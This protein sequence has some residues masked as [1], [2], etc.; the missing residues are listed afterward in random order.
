M[1]TFIFF[2]ALLTAAVAAAV[3]FPLLRRRE[4]SQPA[5]FA[6]IVA[7]AVVVIG[8]SACYVWLSNW[9]WQAPAPANTPETM[10]AQ[11]ARRLERSPD[12][13][14]G[15]L[16]LG[17]SYVV[18]QQY[19]LAT[20][21]YQRADR[22]SD[23]RNV[24]ALTGLAEALALTDESELDGRAGRLL[25]QALAVDPH[26]S[27]A[28]YYG[29][30]V[31]MRRS[32]LP[33]ARQRFA[34]LLELDPPE[35]IKPLLQRQ[36]AALDAQIATGSTAPPVAA[37]ASDA[38]ATAAGEARVRANITL[39]AALRGKV[40]ES[41]PLFVVVREP[42]V[43]GPPLAVKRLTSHF[44]QSVEL[45]SADS[46]IAGRSFKA[47][48]VVEILARVARSGTP[49]GASGDPFGTTTTRVGGNRTLDLV[50]DRITP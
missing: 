43:R 5:P 19:S 45:T 1:S 46:M 9:S 14:E 35:N 40:E 13:L 21:A 32:D 3:A 25:E 17:R 38:P 48:Q 23:G 47:G 18:L 24:E 27:K 37:A 11:L 16:K 10:V 30:L 22:L 44:P 28:L 33:L 12:D 42:G 39:G 29:A 41:T 36:I 4:N 6:A 20:R 50:I 26:S 15:W 31:A 2:A 7:I 49:V 8:G 34:S